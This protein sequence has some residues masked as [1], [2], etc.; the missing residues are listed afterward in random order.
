MYEYFILGFSEARPSIWSVTF[1]SRAYCRFMSLPYFMRGSSTKECASL[2]SSPSLSEGR[3]FCAPASSGV[4]A[5]VSLAGASCGAAARSVPLSSGPASLKSIVP[6]FSP[7]S[8]GTP[9]SSSKRTDAP[10]SVIIRAPSS[11]RS[12]T[13]SFILLPSA[14]IR[15]A[16]PSAFVTI[17]FAMSVSPCLMFSECLF[18]GAEERP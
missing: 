17:C 4:G 2:S 5:S 3:G 18:F 6:V 7:I 1:T 15:Y 14:S 11:M 16:S 10:V 12:P 8:S 9:F 13:R